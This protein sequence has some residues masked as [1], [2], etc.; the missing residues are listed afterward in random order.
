M[1]PIP[2]AGLPRLAFALHTS[3]PVLFSIALVHVCIVDKTFK[4]FHFLGTFISPKARRITIKGYIFANFLTILNV[5]FGVAIRCN[6]F[7]SFPHSPESLFLSPR[8]LRFETSPTCLPV[9]T[10]V[11]LI[12]LLFLFSDRIFNNFLNLQ[13]KETGVQQRI[14]FGSIVAMTFVCLSKNDPF[15][16]V[17][18]VL[19]FS[20]RS[21]GMDGVHGRVGKYYRTSRKICR[22]FALFHAL[23]NLYSPSRFVHRDATAVAFAC[24]LFAA[25]KKMMRAKVE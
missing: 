24:V 14:I 13:S 21:F 7:S 9:S 2:S 19:F 5:F 10:A 11:A 25:R 22:G 3:V 18:M 4:L 6:L 15:A 23:Y 16:L 17:F 8:I 1:E 12:Q 20:E